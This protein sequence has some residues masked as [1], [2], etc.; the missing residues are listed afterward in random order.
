MPALRFRKLPFRFKTGGDFVSQLL[1]DTLRTRYVL[2][3]LSKPGNGSIGT[4][5]I[6]LMTA[7]GFIIQGHGMYRSD[8]FC[9]TKPCITYWSKRITWAIGVMK[10]G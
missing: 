8:N 5:L 1:K 2:F 9:R 6:P 4:R 10:N 3:R 7:F